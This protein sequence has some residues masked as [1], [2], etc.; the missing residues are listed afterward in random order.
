MSLYLDPHLGIAIQ[1]IGQKIERLLRCALERRTVGIEIG[2]TKLGDHSGWRR[3]RGH[4]RRGAALLRS[5][6]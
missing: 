4:R 6:L 1:E 5:D 3:S 2:I